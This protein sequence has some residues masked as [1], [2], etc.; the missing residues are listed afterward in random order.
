MFGRRDIE[1]TAVASSEG[2]ALTPR[3][4]SIEKASEKDSPSGAVAVSARELPRVVE[5]EGIRVVGIAR[6]DEEFY[7]SCSEEFRKRVFRKVGHSKPARFHSCADAILR[8]V[9][10][11]L[12]PVLA[13]IYLIAHIDRSNIG[14]ARIEGLEKDLDLSSTQWSLVLGIF[15]MP[16]MILG[17]R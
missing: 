6:E 10:S 3:S 15:F 2:L 4:L 8:E 13:M 5:L 7:T 1:S 9:D 11:R 16:Y 12:L 17:T 14:N